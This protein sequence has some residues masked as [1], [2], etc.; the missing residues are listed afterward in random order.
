MRFLTCEPNFKGDEKYLDEADKFYEAPMKWI[1]SHLPVHPIS[2][3]P[4][5]LVVYDTL[6]PKIKDFLSIYKP[7]EAFFHSDHLLESRMGHNVLI[8]E[9]IEQVAKKKEE[10]PKQDEAEEPATKKSSQDEL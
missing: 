2:A 9:R 8:F 10:E 6:A 5:H 3:L 4:T 1:R 7:L